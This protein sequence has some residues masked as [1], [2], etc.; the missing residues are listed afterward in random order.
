MVIMTRYLVSTMVSATAL[1]LF[2]SMV[3]FFPHYH[4]P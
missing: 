2:F 4:H 3:S 1:C